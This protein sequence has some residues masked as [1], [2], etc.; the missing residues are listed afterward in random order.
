MK[1]EVQEHHT[2]EDIVEQTDSEEQPKSQM[3][4][5]EEKE[6]VAKLA[7]DQNV[8]TAAA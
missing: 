4:L 3:K 2:W 1:I 8:E 5:Q 6:T 7:T